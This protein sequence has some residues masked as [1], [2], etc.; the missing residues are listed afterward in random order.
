LGTGSA[1]F[2]PIEKSIIKDTSV[3]FVDDTSQFLNPLG[4][5]LT[6]NSTSK[7]G[8]DLL[9]YASRNSQIWADSIWVSGGSLYTFKCFYYAFLPTVEYK[10][11]TT[12]CIDLPMPEQLR[13]LNKQTNTLLPIERIPL[14]ECHRML[15][16][17]KLLLHYHSSSA[18][19]EAVC[20]NQGVINRCSSAR[21]NH[22]RN[23]REKNTDLFLTQQQTQN[24]I[25]IN[26]T[27][28]KS[29]ADKK[30][31]KCLK[32]L[33]D[34][35]L[36]RDEVYNV[37]CN[38]TANNAWMN[39]TPVDDPAVTPAEQWALY[40]CHPTYHKITGDVTT[41][42]YS[43]MGFENLQN[44]VSTKH[45][46]PNGALHDC[47]LHSLRRYLSSEKPM[48]RATLIKLIHG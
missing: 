11:N 10:K 36:T 27:W 39:S 18:R 31:W 14:D 3:Q 26:L 37:W 30:P 17:S 42:I 2:H 35:N 5:E 40:S 25:P 29:H 28:V 7:I 24:S 22:L 8:S 43:A 34:Q 15:G 46:I 12:K 41:A 33:L 47:D 19:V 21:F 13:I 20:D 16:V 4:A 1:C 32:D 9:P 44:Y 23:H 45:G 6:S 38:H 48:W